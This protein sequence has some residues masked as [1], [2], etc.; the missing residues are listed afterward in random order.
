[1][2]Q[3]KKHLFLFT[4]GPVQS[5]I[6]QA[7][8]TQDLYAGSQLLSD[9]IAFALGYIQL[10]G[11]E[12]IF[13]YYSR[14]GVTFDLE[15][16]STSYP[17][18]FVAILNYS[19]EEQN[20]VTILGQSLENLLRKQLE[21]LAKKK[22]EIIP[23]QYR[24]SGL[25]EQIEDF[26]EVYWVAMPYDKKGK[27]NEQFKTLE[28]YLGAVKNVRSF[29]QLVE[30]GRKCSVNGEYNVKIY[31]KTEEEEKQPR[32][33]IRKTKLFANDNYILCKNYR[34]IDNRH[35]QSGEGLCAIS[36]LKRLYRDEDSFPST[37]EIALLNNTHI[38]TKIAQL[39]KSFGKHFD[40]QL[41]FD[42]NLTEKYFEKHGLNDKKLPPKARDIVNSIKQVA[43]DQI[44]MNSYYALLS[45]D[46]DSMGE[47]LSKAKNQ[48]EHKEFSKLLIDFAQKAKEKVDAVGKTVYAG[49]D[50]FLGFVNL[51][52]LFETIEYLKEVFKEC[53]TKKNPIV[54]GD[55]KFTM[56]IGLVI[57][58]YKTPLRQV[59]KQAK[60]LEKGAKEFLY[61]KKRRK[62]NI[63]FCYMTTNNILAEGYLSNDDWWVL[64]QLTNYFKEEKLSSKFAFS[65]MQSTALLHKEIDWETFNILKDGLKIELSRLI[66]RSA[67][68]IFKTE[69]KSN[70]EKVI[71]EFIEGLTTVFI[72]NEVDEKG[73]VKINITNFIGM[74]KFAHNLSAKLKKND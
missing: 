10:Q 63:G 19:L 9:L 60:K 55:K 20:K 12:I 73:I 65:F 72:K 48:S 47:W 16:N 64:K 52:Y 27:Y 61:Q 44:K 28:S 36:F 41:L 57:A 15:K 70:G 50:D 34:D 38:A 29:R 43:K 40:Y 5:F 56:S 30:K 21:G 71:D 13:P 68:P 32:E 22:F 3:N 59:I 17:N 42:E 46:G 49:G 6:A 11:H 35:I 14:N 18:R 26:L 8:K 54:D 24:P 23:A 37:A 33:K 2:S 51:E 4:I 25:C 31:Q 66:K 45:F 7:R 74:L 53:V 39:R 69:R 62:N 58:H 1:M 67:T